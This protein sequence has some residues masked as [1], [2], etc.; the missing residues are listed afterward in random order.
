[1]SYNAQDSPP[2][3]R[4]IIHLT[5]LIIPSLRNPA[6]GNFKKQY[7]CLD[8]CFSKVWCMDQQF[9]HQ[10]G[11]QCLWNL[12]RWS[13]PSAKAENHCLSFSPTIPASW[14]LTAISIL[15]SCYGYGYIEFNWKNKTKKFATCNKHHILEL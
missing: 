5:R 1:M 8:L 10:V 6:I 7:Y 13:Q 12:P 3:Q 9:W 11:H 4:W 15:V 2:P 14:R